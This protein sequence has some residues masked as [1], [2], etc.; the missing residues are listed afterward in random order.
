MV[1]TLT[2]SLAEKLTGDEAGWEV[3]M[4]TSEQNVLVNNHSNSEQGSVT[5]RME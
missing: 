1:P 5:Q 4:A 3:S 2:A